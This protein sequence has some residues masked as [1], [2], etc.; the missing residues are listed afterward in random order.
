MKKFA[1]E[2]L[3]GLFVLAGLLCTIYLSVNLGDMRVFGIQN[4]YL[5]KARFN[6]VQGLTEGSRVSIAGVKVGQIETITLDPEAYV[7]FV[8]MR[9]D[10]G[11][12]LYDDAIASIRTNGLIGDRYILISPGGSGIELEP[13]ETIVDT[14]SA[15]D[16]ESL[17][18]KMAFGDVEEK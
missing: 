10:K 3:V 7:A 14:E 2:T 15:I 5:I 16:L 9:I 13:G 17:I 11:V 12:L 1:H 4:D 18:S 6:S 8:D